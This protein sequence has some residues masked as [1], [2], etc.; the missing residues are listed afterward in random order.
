MP[1]TARPHAITGATIDCRGDAPMDGGEGEEPKPHGRL[2]RH[3]HRLATGHT[4]GLLARHTDHSYS[5]GRLVRA[6]RW[7]SAPQS[8]ATAL[9][10]ATRGDARLIEVSDRDRRRCREAVL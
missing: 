6:I 8:N 10:S 7:T 5:G 9:R 3:T 1:D 2:T 4:D